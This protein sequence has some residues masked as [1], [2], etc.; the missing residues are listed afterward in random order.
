MHRS[1]MKELVGKLRIG[2][3]TIKPKIK[4]AG[5]RPRIAGLETPKSDDLHEDIANL[6][7]L[8]SVVRERIRH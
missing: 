3:R 7:T 5:N 6:R 1:S 2:R 4:L 8:K